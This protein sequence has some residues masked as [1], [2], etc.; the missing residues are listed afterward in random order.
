MAASKVLS[1][2][3]MAKVARCTGD[4]KPLLVNMD[5][6]RM[7]VNYG[8]QK[9]LRVLRRSLPRGLKHKKEQLSSAE[10]KAG[11]TYIAFITHDTSVQPKLPQILLGNEHV[12]T[13][14]LLSD[15]RQTTPGNFRLWR[16][17]S[18]WNNHK[19]MCQI[20]RLLWQCL[21]DYL[22][23]HQVILVLDVARS[24]FHSTSFGLANRLGIRLVYVPGKMT[25]LLQPLDTHCFSKL[26][27]VLKRKWVD[28]RVESPSGDLSHAAW[29]TA[30]FEVVKKL[31]CGTRW[32]PAFR[33][34]LDEADLSARVLE[35]LGW[36][37]PRPVAG[38]AL[39]E[40]QLKVIFPKR[41]RVNRASLLKW[42]LPAPKAKPKAKAKA[43]AASSA[44]SAAL[45]SSDVPHGVA[46]EA[47]PISSYT[48]AKRRKAM[49]S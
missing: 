20:L 22:H 38:E 2:L 19:V 25:W 49:E 39:S 47:G 3:Q 4:K 42:C 32:Y 6:T 13:L 28:L 10:E 24:H 36:E 26:K 34:L 37:A 21:K 30:V 18:S 48:R 14:K 46:G 44:A 41:A 43:K 40:E 45:S 27:R 29:F 35:E 15:L 17:E 5:E 33:A 9:G 7:L 1:Y 16:R 12:M 23:S 8:K 11:L 31:L